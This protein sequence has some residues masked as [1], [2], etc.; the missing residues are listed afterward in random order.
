M[1]DEESGKVDE[2]WVSR[3]RPP[4]IAGGGSSPV[5]NRRG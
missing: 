3:S 1:E 2:N 5:R 4:V